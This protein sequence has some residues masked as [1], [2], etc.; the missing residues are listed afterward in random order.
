MPPRP[1]QRRP[2][3]AVD[4][5]DDGEAEGCAAA[6]AEPDGAEGTEL[7]CG[8]PVPG[9]GDRDGLTVG[10]YGGEVEGAAEGESGDG[11]ADG[12]TDGDGPS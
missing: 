6:V 7:G 11:D 3:E 2:G 12:T 9:C 5:G 4:G 8:A 10:T 1:P